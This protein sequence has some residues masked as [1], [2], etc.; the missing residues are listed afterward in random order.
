M[1]I[2]RQRF[3]SLIGK[4]IGH[5]GGYVNDPNDPGGETKYG[6]SKRS[7]P[8][9]NIKT[10]TLRQACD[11]YYRDWWTKLQCSQIKHDAI[12]Q[13]LMDTAVN[14]GVGTGVRIAQKALKDIGAKVTV[15]GKIGPQTIGAI[16][17]AQPNTLLQAMRNRQAEHYR[18]LIERNP[19]LAKYE[20]GWLSRAN[21]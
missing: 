12:A 17:S 18:K 2:D 10:L 13:K 7:Y 3:D 15:D 11:I 4:V 21:S 16:N 1:M 14:V 5:E 19:A 6:I 9:I 20:R 8:N